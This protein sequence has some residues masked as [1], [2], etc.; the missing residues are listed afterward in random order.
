M[1]AAA[2]P[3]HIISKMT[4][5]GGHQARVVVFKFSS[6]LPQIRGENFHHGQINL[7]APASRTRN[8][9]FWAKHQIGDVEFL[10]PSGMWREEAHETKPKKRSQ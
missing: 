2:L 8:S 7:V 5:Q 6:R 9:I 1:A 3:S 10:P 4:K